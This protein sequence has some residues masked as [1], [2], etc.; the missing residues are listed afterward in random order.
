MSTDSN[1]MCNVKPKKKTTPTDAG[2]ARYYRSNGNRVKKNEH[3]KKKEQK[4]RE[5]R[6]N[7]EGRNNPKK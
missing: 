7:K 2:C 5:N 6:K 3:D 1:A 4:R